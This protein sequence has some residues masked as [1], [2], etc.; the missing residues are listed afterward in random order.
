MYELSLIK[1]PSGRY[2]FVG[3]VPASLAFSPE[4]TQKQIDNS[5]RFGV[6][7]GK[8]KR[9]VFDTVAQAA[10]AAQAAGYTF[11]DHSG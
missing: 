5:I 3:T 1:F 2:G 9:L 7:I 11:A 6:G 10:Q 4:S 8:A